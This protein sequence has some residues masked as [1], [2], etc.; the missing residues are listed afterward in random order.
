MSSE[1]SSAATTM[2][3]QALP[4]RSVQANG[5]G[6]RPSLAG[7]RAT[8]VV[9]SVQAFSAPMPETTA[10]AATSFPAQTPCVKIVWNAVTNGAVLLTSA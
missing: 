4:L 9:T 5:L 10:I 6:N 8:S 1:G 7:A 3:N 2:P